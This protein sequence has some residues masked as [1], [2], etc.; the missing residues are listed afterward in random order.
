MNLSLLKIIGILVAI[1]TIITS[2]VAKATTIN[3][4]RRLS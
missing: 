2:I 3:A 1:A 4:Y